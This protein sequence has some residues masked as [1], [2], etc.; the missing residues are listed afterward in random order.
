MRAYVLAGRLGGGK[1][2]FLGY[3]TQHSANNIT[4]EVAVLNTACLMMLG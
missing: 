4:Y 3:A 1:L 2:G